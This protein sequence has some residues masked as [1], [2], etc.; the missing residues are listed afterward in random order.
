MVVDLATAL[1]SEISLDT[2]RY[3]DRH[4]QKKRQRSDRN[5]FCVCFPLLPHLLSFLDQLAGTRF[6]IH[7]MSL[8]YIL[9]FTLLDVKDVPL[10]LFCI[11]NRWNIILGMFDSEN[12][13]IFAGYSH[14]S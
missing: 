3:I 8:T 12:I 2:L 4:F 10:P 13:L 5:E 6:N 7:I 9:L 11:Q 14:G 1:I